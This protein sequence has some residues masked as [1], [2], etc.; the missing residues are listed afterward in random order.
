[1]NGL[2]GEWHILGVDY[3]GEPL[4]G[5]T[6]R[7]QIIAPRFAIQIGGTPRE[8]GG[9][10][11][12]SSAEPASLDLIWRDHGGGEVRRIRAIV[13]RRGTLMQ[14]CYYPEGGTSRPTTFDTLPTA[15]TPPA[16]L[17]RCRLEVA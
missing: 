6:G 4:P 15:T 17:V 16:I 8:V 1:M 2:D 14:F 9:V 13:R 3:A 12:V 11:F 5:R 7:L 10:E